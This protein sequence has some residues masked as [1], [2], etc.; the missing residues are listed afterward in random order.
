VRDAKCHRR[1]Y[2]VLEKLLHGGTPPPPVPLFSASKPS[3]SPFQLRKTLRPSF[4]SSSFTKMPLKSLLLPLCVLAALASSFLPLATADA[5]GFT[6]KF[7]LKNSSFYVPQNSKTFVPI[8]NQAFFL[9]YADNTHLKVA[10]S[11]RA[12]VFCCAV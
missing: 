6:E 10:C 4:L 3:S 7:D 5:D 11:S 8:K 2:L 9:G 12:L 1:K